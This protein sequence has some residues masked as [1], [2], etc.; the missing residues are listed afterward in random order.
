M[1]DLI[2]RSTSLKTMMLYIT[3]IQLHAYK[4]KGKFR[5]IFCGICVES[6]TLRNYLH[7]SSSLQN[8]DGYNFTR[9]AVLLFIGSECSLSD[10]FKHHIGFP[11]IRPRVPPSGLVLFTLFMHLL[12]VNH[13]KLPHSNHYRN[14]YSRKYFFVHKREFV[15]YSLWSLSF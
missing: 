4:H 13:S 7:S 1:E 3:S 14:K 2:A 6:F 10:Q 11:V 8:T 5:P 15:R 9:S 12:L